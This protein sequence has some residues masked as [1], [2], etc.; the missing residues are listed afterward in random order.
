VNDVEINYWAITSELAYRQTG[1]N[2]QLPDVGYNYLEGGEKK[3]AY[4]IDPDSGDKVAAVN[5]VALNSNGSLK[6]AGQL[7]DILDRRV[8]REVDF[9]SYFGRPSWL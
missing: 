8:N 2:L 7:P 3:R 1:W 9:S 5:P 4:V 6:T